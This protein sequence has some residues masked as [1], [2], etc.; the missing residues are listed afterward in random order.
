[1][2]YVLR[3]ACILPYSLFSRPLSKFALTLLLYS[4]ALVRHACVHVR[5]E[6]ILVTMDRCRADRADNFVAAS[7]HTSYRSRVL[8]LFAQRRTSIEGK[9][10]S[11][12]AFQPAT[13]HSRR[14]FGHHRS[15]IA[16]IARHPF[17]CSSESALR[18]RRRFPQVDWRLDS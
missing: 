7:R 10:T 13:A 5:V 17:L 15:E 2:T 8:V 18:E 14:G 11:Q 12:T 1:M 9:R 4:P 3:V 16:V 6:D